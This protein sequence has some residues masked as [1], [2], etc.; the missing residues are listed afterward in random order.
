MKKILIIRF[1][2]IG[3]IVLTSPVIRT[4]KT[5]PK[6]FEIHFIT[7]KR[8][9]PIVENNPYLDK[10][11]TIEKEIDEVISDLKKENYD[12][13]IDLHNNLRSHRLT[14]MLGVKC[15]RLKKLNF[16]KW[17]LVQFKINKLT[18][19]HI[20][21][22]YLET[23]RLLDLEY[24]N[25]G[26]DYYILPEDESEVDNI[27]KIIGEKFHVFVM[28]GA[29]ITKQIPTKIL[30]KIAKSSNLPI[31]LLGG[32][33]DFKKAVEISNS[34][35]EK[36]IFNACGILSINES[37]A[38]V[39]SAQKVLTSDTGMMHIAAAF[40][41]PI[42]S[43]W[44][45]TVPAFGMYPYFPEAEKHLSQMFEVQGLSCRPCSKIGFS[46]CPKKH[47]NCMMKQD[48]AEIIKSLNAF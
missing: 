23:I 29:H 1:S 44:G 4:I 31:V 3:D 46:E 36:R 48:V 39:K 13:I 12:L 27:R 9:L 5:N 43:L 6:D 38:L 22:R 18:D 47:F 17:L 7:K 33:E 34:V 45:N 15:F 2:S 37:A 26:L 25:R 8:F 19:I 30:V 20:V 14:I 16:R 28:G 10:I 11:F 32:K 35:N 42:I 21:D 24:Q 41:K 40:H